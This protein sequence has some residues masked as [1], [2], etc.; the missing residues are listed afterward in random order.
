MLRYFITNNIYI[1]DLAKLFSFN[2]NYKRVYY[3]TYILNLVSQNILFST[4]KEA[5]K[6]DLENI[7]VSL[8]ISC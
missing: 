8:L 4:N 2:I 1:R 3:T 5:Y 7:L 6:N